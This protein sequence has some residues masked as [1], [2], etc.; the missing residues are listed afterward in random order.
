[1]TRRRVREPLAH[2]LTE[3]CPA[4]DGVGRVPTFATT[5][6]ELLRAI[7]REAAHGAGALDAERRRQLERRI[8]RAVEW[9]TEPDWPRGHWDVTVAS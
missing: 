4:C 8:G 9:R 1:M 2:L 5:L 6:A 3:S 7:E